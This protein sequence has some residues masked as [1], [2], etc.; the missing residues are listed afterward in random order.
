MN[1]VRSLLGILLGYVVCT[2]AAMAVVGWLFGRPEEPGTGPIVAGL[3]AFLVASI[4]A[5][6]LSAVVAGRRPLVY[7]GTVAAIFT[8]VLVV[9]LARSSSVEP[10]WYT[11]TTLILGVPAILGGGLLAPLVVLR[12]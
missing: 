8:V 3:L 9:S 11:L 1:L 6:F 12:D 10:S 7:A 2:A 4:L 5:G